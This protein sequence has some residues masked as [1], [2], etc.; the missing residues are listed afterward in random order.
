M[1]VRAIL[2]KIVSYNT[3][4]FHEIIVDLNL[5]LLCARGGEEITCEKY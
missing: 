3:Y 1:A 5:Q 4:I 2:L